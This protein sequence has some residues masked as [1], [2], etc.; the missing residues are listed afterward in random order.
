MVALSWIALLPYF[1]FEAKI[2]EMKES[3]AAFSPGEAINV[4]GN[5]LLEQ[6]QN[7][8]FSGI[9]EKVQDI[10]QAAVSLF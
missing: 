5:W 10:V 8:D 4:G 3:L 6:I 1:F 2:E 7:I 9:A